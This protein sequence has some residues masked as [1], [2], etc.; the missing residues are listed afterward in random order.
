MERSKE[1]SPVLKQS[2]R[3]EVLMEIPDI[4]LPQAMAAI[5]VGLVPGGVGSLA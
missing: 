4:I 3:C 1:A 2:Y 5:A